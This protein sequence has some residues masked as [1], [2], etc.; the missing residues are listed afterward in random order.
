MS[1]TVPLFQ[2]VTERVQGVTSGSR[3][4]VTVG[5]RLALLVTG[6]LAARTTVISQVAAE[7]AAL[8]LSA[9]TEERIARRL[10]R[11]LAA[12]LPPADLYGPAV[13]WDDVRHR[14]G[15][16]SLCVDESS[17]DERVHLLRLSLAYRGGAVTL[18]WQVWEQN[19]RL[20]EG[21][22]WQA[23]DQ[24]LDAAAALLPPGLS[25]TVLADRAYDIPPFLDRLTA[26]GWSYVVRLKLGSTVFRDH[27]GRVQ[28]LRALIERHV[29]RPGQR[30]KGRGQ[31]FKTAGWRSV[32]VVAY[33]QP[34]E[35]ERLVVVTDGPPCWTALAAYGRR[36]WC[37]TAFRADKTAG[38]HW[39][40]SQVRGMHHHAQLLLAMA[41]ASLIAVCLGVEAATPDPRRPGNLTAPRAFCCV[42]RCK[43]PLHDDAREQPT[44]A[45][46]PTA[47]KGGR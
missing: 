34:D 21:A 28:P 7:L 33:W 4:R 42:L 1:A 19:A 16:V 32:S 13:D 35:D 39:E 11:T 43:E 30:W 8:A 9:A 25:V 36:F 20:A 12:P 47:D 6:I 22:Y 45:V 44:E 27:Q 17:Q 41:W 31:L 29:Q 26:R 24:V 18:S 46:H 38:W 5:R 40:Q 23:M 14:G 15:R 3:V 10:R 37:E 2:A